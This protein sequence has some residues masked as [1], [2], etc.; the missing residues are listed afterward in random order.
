VIVIDTREQRPYE[1]SDGTL[2]AVEGMH[3]GDYSVR[4]SDGNP[5]GDFTERVVVERKSL[6]DY[7][8]SSIHGRARFI[9]ELERLS[10]YERACIVVEGDPVDAHEGKYRSRTNPASI[11]GSAAAFF[12]DYGVPT[13]FWGNRAAATE[14]TER[15]LKKFYER[16]MKEIRRNIEQ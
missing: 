14:F 7:V 12:V 15:F 4:S 6:E 13:M 2:T 5:A 9:R 3:T 16:K 11:V 8:G 1:F 10:L